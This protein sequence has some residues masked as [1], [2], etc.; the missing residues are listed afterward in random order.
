MAV[1]AFSIELQQFKTKLQD[2]LIKDLHKPAASKAIHEALLPFIN[3][4]VP[5]NNGILS[6][7]RGNMPGK[8]RK[9]GKANSTGITW[10]TVY[11]DYVNNGDAYGK[12]IP[13]HAKGDRNTVIGFYSTPIQSPTGGFLKYSTPGT[14]DHWKGRFIDAMTG[15][16]RSVVNNAVTRKLKKVRKG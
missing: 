15:S 3:E 1:K 2:E 6:R 11:A 12:H 4:F 5:E 16:Y 10:N 13:I 7:N 9:S 8:L 14:G